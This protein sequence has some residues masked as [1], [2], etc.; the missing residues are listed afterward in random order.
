MSQLDELIVHLETAEKAMLELAALVPEWQ[1]IE[2]APKDGTYVLLGGGK[3]FCE[4]HACYINGSAVAAFT[5]D[6]AW[7]IA[8]PAGGFVWVTYKEPTHWMPLPPPPKIDA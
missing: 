4:E 7:L 1:P 8:A 2:T 6:S 3:Y 5:T